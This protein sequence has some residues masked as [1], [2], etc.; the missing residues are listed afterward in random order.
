[1]TELH[2]KPGTPD[3]AFPCFSP[4]LS[5]MSLSPP[6]NHSQSCQTQPEPNPNPIQTHPDSKTRWTAATPLPS[7]TLKPPA[8][9]IISRPAITLN[10]SE[11]SK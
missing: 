2:A 3:S 8:R 10:M 4:V 11:M 7:G 1:M 5:G 9:R 6:T